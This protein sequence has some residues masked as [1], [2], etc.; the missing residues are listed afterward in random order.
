MAS[1][2]V[3]TSLHRA[4]QV[5]A[6]AGVL[7]RHFTFTMSLHIQVYKWVPE[8]PLFASCYGNQDK[9]P[10]DGHLARMQTLPC[11]GKV[12]KFKTKLAWEIICRKVIL[13]KIF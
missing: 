3:C 13:K 4:V 10:P 5:R 1:R 8:I 9:L 6:L 12:S 7:T 2:L 11:G